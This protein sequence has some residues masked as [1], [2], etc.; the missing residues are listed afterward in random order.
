MWSG[1]HFGDSPG[2]FTAVMAGLPMLPVAPGIAPET[3]HM[4]ERP[5]EDVTLTG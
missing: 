1:G 2:S 4:G 3:A 5:R